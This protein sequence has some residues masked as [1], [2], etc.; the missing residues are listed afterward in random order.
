[1]F[2]HLVRSR[3]KKPK[4]QV[5]TKRKGSSNFK[6]GQGT[7]PL[8]LINDLIKAEK[9]ISKKMIYLEFACGGLRISEPLHRFVTDVLPGRT[10]PML[11][12]RDTP[13][14]LPLVIL[15][16]PVE[17]L[18]TDSLNINSTTNRRQYL[19][20]NYGLY[21]RNEI[22]NGSLRAGWKGML[23]DNGDLKISQIYWSNYYYAKLYFELYKQLMHIR[24]SVPKSIRDSHPYLYIVD[25]SKVK[26]FGQQLT[27]GNIE[28]SFARACKKIGLIPYR[29]KATPHG[30]R[31]GYK[32]QLEKLQL[33][34]S[35]IQ[36]CMHHKSIG[37]QA[38]YALP[39]SKEINKKLFDILNVR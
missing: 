34:A 36:V 22:K 33:S 4:Y 38:A 35:E 14:E 19:L 32:K 37:S 24:Q 21:P 16:D 12:P 15:A 11:F 27:I 5:T 13:S 31:H 28:K 17:S 23:Y 9:S 25:N 8:E 30:L 39:D 6:R 29:N 10:R 26:Q 20:K 7:F 2:T 18:Y 3:R 1:M